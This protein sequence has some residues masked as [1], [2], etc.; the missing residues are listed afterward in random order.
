[1]TVL[2]ARGDLFTWCAA[3]LLPRPQPRPPL[4]HVKFHNV[5]FMVGADVQLALEFNDLAGIRDDRPMRV[6]VTAQDG[7]ISLNLQYEAISRQP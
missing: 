3:C 7:P 2:L 6:M 4:R 1:M 5:G